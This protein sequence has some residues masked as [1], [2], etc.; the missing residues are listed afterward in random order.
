MYFGKA[1]SEKGRTVVAAV[2]HAITSRE[3]HSEFT[4]Y[5][6][7]QSHSHAI[8]FSIR[9]QAVFAK[10]RFSYHVQLSSKETTL[11]NILYYKI[12]STILRN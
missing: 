1:T 8:K 12:C 2:L 6:A 4:F 7:A 11:K 9:D 10:S 5:K 3:S